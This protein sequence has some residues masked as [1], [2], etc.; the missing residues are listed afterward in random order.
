MSLHDRQYMPSPIVQSVPPRPLSPKKRDRPLSRALMLVERIAD[1]AQQPPDLTITPQRI[2]VL[3]SCCLGDA[4]LAT[5]LLRAL[6]RAYPRARLVAGIGRW[7]RPALLNN[8]DI[9]GLLDLEAL[10]V[11]RLQPDAYAHVLRRLRAGRF[12]LALVL[13]RTP[14]LTMLPLLAGI[15]VRAG[16]DSAG[17]GFPLNV[18]VPWAEVEH[19][20]RLFLRIAAALGLPDGDVRACFVPTPA[21]EAGASELWR[22]AGLAGERV[23]ALAP[24]GGHNPGMTLDAKR[25]PA[26]RFAALADALHREH[27]LAVLLTG[28]ESDRAVTAEVRRL[29]QAPAA[30]LSGQTNFGV[31]GAL[32]ARCALFAGNDSAPM[33]LAAAVGTPVLAIFG[34]TD[35]AVYA[36]LTPHGIVLRGLSGY[37]TEEVGVEEA[38]QAAARLLTTDN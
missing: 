3:K 32:L 12:D 18:R 25:W 38:I 10:G 5:P 21:D 23:V 20:A 36:P 13:D 27:G 15:P 4:L 2:V 30:D 16:I 17:R 14:L 8:P 6:R 33:H 22:Q 37:S 9:D 1:L 7:S 11:G 34:P 35:P 19:E 29:M 31:L 28:A 26:A 24:G